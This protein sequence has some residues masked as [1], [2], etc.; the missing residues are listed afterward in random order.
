MLRFGHQLADHGLDHTNVSIQ[1]SAKDSTNQRDPDVG[2]ESEDHHA[3]H[4]ASAAYEQDWLSPNAVRQTSPIHAH[5][6]LREREGRDEQAGVGGCIFLVADLESLHELPGIR[7]DRS[8]SDGFSK[9]DNSLM[10]V[11]HARS[12]ARGYV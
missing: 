7:K 2:S 4:G 6:G 5:H 9:A 3:D 8:E 11:S 1:C 12:E 10:S